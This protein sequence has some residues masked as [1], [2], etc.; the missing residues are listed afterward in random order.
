M[1]FEAFCILFSLSILCNSFIE[2]NLLKKFKS[3]WSDKDN[4]NLILRLSPYSLMANFNDVLDK[5]STKLLRRNSWTDYCSFYPCKTFWKRCRVKQFSSCDNLIC[6][7]PV[8]KLFAGDSE[9]SNSPHPGVILLWWCPIVLMVSGC[10]SVNAPLLWKMVHEV[11]EDGELSLVDTSERE[12]S[13]ASQSSGLL[14]AVGWQDLMMTL[15]KMRPR[16]GMY[17]NYWYV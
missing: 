12:E 11:Y 8:K 3:V 2:V 4:P 6:E 14:S 17:K 15:R 1:L 5:P 7:D 16:C 9:K 10:P 13:E